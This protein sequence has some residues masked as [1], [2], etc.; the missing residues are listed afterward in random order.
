[1]NQATGQPTRSDPKTLLRDYLQGQNREQ[2][3][4]QLVTH[5]SPLI[6][7][8][9]LR[10]CRNS[11]LAEEVTQN[12]LTLIARKAPSLLKHPNLTAWVFLT[13]RLET[14]TVMRTEHRRHQKHQSYHFDSS[15]LQNT[16]WDP[17]DQAAWQE[18][19]PYLDKALDQ[20]SDRDRE[21]ILK[22]FFENQ[23]F[24][25]IARILKCSEGACKMQLKRALERLGAALTSH[26][27]TLS[28]AT[29]G[30][31]LLASLA[32]TS[33]SKAAAT[34]ASHAITN[35]NALS[36][37]TTLTN[38]IATMTNTQKIITASI[39]LFTATSIPAVQMAKESS[40]LQSQLQT[41]ESRS[42]ALKKTANSQPA[43][44][45]SQRPR[46][47]VQQMLA[48]QSKHLDALTLLTR[49][50]QAQQ[51]MDIMAIMGIFLPLAEM[52]Q[53]Q[54]EELLAELQTIEDYP[55]E[56]RTG[57]I[58][59]VSRFLA[60]KGEDTHQQQ[61]DELLSSDAFST[62]AAYT[63]SNILK[64]WAEKNPAQALAWFQENESSGAL[65]GKGVYDHSAT[66]FEALLSGMQ[67][68]APDQA[69][70]LYWQANE[71]WRT[72]AFRLFIKP[73]VQQYE[74]SNDISEL[75][76]FIAQETNPSLKEHVLDT[77]SKS[78]NSLSSI[79]EINQLDEDNPHSALRLGNAI[80]NQQWPFEEKAT[81]LRENLS[82]ED[83]EANLRNLL[84][85]STQETTEVLTWIHQQD[86]LELRDQ[87][88]S[89]F[90]EII[91]TSQQF[92]TAYEMAKEI[93]NE[94]L[95]ESSLIE[96]STRWHQEIPSAAQKHVAP[97]IL[98]KIR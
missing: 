43:S 30:T 60:E 35:A 79:L 31:G 16:E 32:A 56:S 28:A 1:M 73:I 4:T 34:L 42:L 9:A 41:L 76:D 91:S 6:Y 38:T 81:A 86:D 18:A 8:S 66:Y 65:T 62:N 19:L 90:S 94:T 5:Y 85:N 40:R 69:L 96:V 63:N 37:T 45:L 55:L 82:Q 33:P 14:R 61:L 64:D 68:K 78:A 49:L 97:E 70:Q 84:N 24:K 21:L 52:N 13:T 22:R 51:S 39:L 87:S 12:V 26:S 11:V 77:A 20:L 74:Q 15:A 44:L 50:S 72:I 23:K 10:R 36:T 58:H 80:A 7:S 92:Q 75:R 53:D 47:T 67:E 48:S 25:D 89:T 88:L 27:G 71:H 59:F 17:K 98:E 29:V 93:Q 2:A 95:R 3:F 46:R 83:F 57:A 54:L